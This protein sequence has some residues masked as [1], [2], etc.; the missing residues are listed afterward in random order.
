MNAHAPARLRTLVTGLALLSLASV[1]HVAAGSLAAPQSPPPAEH[2]YMIS[3]DG[4][5][6]E[7]Y[8]DDSWPAPTLQW[9]AREGASADSVRSV[10]PTITYPAHTTIITGALPARHGI[11]YNSPFEPDGQTGRWYWEADLIQVPTLWD[12]VGAAGGTSASFW[13]PVSVGAPIDYNVPEIWSLEDGYGTDEPLR[14]NDTPDG[15]IE[16]LEREATGRFNAG[17]LSGDYLTRE[18]LTSAAAA[19]TIETYRPTFMTVHLIG[20]DHFQHVDGRDSVKVRQSVAAVDTAIFELVDAATR[21]GILERTAFVIAGDHG[22]VDIHSSLAPNVWL[23]EAGLLE[24]QR[25]RGDWRAAFHS[26]VASAFLYLKDPADTATAERVRNIVE[27]RPRAER[28][29]YRIVDR[30]ELA[31][32]GADPNAALALAFVP[33]ISFNAGADGPALRPSGGGTHGFYPDFDDIE[34]GFIGWGAGFGKG[35][36]VPEMGLEDIAPTIAHLLGIA[37]EAPDGALYP[38]LFARPAGR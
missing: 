10:F 30:D 37:F 5:R 11:Y 6:P 7:F 31:A 13:W 34:T 21:A 25:D 17:N 24:P 36:V 9:M 16:E 32:I 20:V 14:W 12:A 26:G 15:F 23:A 8:R 2:V 29:L 38:G 3:V 33:G 19:Y 22:F 1:G 18:R 35:V 4:L 27:S 28:R